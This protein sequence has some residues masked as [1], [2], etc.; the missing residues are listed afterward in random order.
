MLLSYFNPL[1]F[2]GNSMYH[3]PLHY[4]TLHFVTLLYIFTSVYDSYNKYQILL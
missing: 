3:L 4:E 1:N 2:S